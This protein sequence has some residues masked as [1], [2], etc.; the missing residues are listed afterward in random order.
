MLTAVAGKSR[1]L[2]ISPPKGEET[3]LDD[4]VRYALFGAR[5]TCAGPTPLGE[6]ERGAPPHQN[7]VLVLGQK[8]D[9]LAVIG[10]ALWRFHNAHQFP[11]TTAVPLL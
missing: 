8:E 2:F 11:A 10:I 1:H 4:G 3:L 7:Q 5:T 9:S 6:V